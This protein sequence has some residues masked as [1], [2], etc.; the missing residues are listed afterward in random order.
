MRAFAGCTFLE[1][2]TVYA[3]EVDILKDA[4]IKNPNYSRMKSQ[5][6]LNVQLLELKVL[7]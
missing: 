7:L 6:L 2:V 4:W 3:G 1:S 5:Y